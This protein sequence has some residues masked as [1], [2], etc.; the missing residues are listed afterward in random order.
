MT[1][2]EALLEVGS[3]RSRDNAFCMIVCS[4]VGGLVDESAVLLDRILLL[5]SAS[6]VTSCDTRYDTED[7]SSLRL[8]SL[9][10]GERSRSSR[11]N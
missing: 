6:M 9:G 1:L 11:T 4:G 7:R 5:C 3:L 2:F 8:G 10:E